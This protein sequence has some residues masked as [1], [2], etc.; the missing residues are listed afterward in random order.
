MESKTVHG[1]LLMKGL[2]RSG[3]SLVFLRGADGLTFTHMPLWELEYYLAL[4]GNEFPYR[5][6]RV[7]GADFPAYRIIMPENMVAALPEW[8]KPPAT[9]ARWYY[10]NMGLCYEHLLPLEVEFGVQPPEPPF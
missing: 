4:C 6:R 9:V 3:E 10:E 2:G 1:W 7:F 5:Q 8:L